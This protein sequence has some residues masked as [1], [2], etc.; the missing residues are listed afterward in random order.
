MYRHHTEVSGGDRPFGAVS[1]PAVSATDTDTDTGESGRLPYYFGY[2]SLP[3]RVD[4]LG[5]LPV[6][7]RRDFVSELFIP[8]RF[9]L[10]QLICILREIY[11]ISPINDRRPGPDVLLQSTCT[12]HAC[13]R[14]T[15]QLSSYCTSMYGDQ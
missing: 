12:C 1:E 11:V 5:L 15:D 8:T 9:V 4:I 7:C 14:L 6:D 10:P 2:Y 3:Q 13:C